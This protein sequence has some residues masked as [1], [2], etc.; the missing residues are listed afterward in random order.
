MSMENDYVDEHQAFAASRSSDYVYETGSRVAFHALDSHAETIEGDVK[1][2]FVIT[3]AAGCGKSALLANWVSLRR[4]TKHRDEF[5]FQHFVGCSPQSKQLAHLLHRLE[6]ALKEHFQLREMEIPTSEERLRW[7]LNRFLTAAGKK[8]FPARIV[9]VLDAVNCLLGE[10]STANTLHWLPSQLPQGVRIIVSTVELEQFGSNPEGLFDESRIHRTYTE[11]RRRK[12][13]T[14]HLQP[15]SV[16]VRHLII[17]SFLATNQQSLQLLK[18]AQQFRIV[19]AKASSQPLF[20]RT[21]LYA[22]LLGSEMS[23]ATIDQQV[24]IYLAAEVTPVLIARI[25][26]MCSGYVDSTCI[27]AANNLR[28]ILTALYSSRHGLSEIEMWGVAELATG[29][30]L[31]HEQ[32]ACIRRILR[33]FTFSV[34]GLRSLSHVEYAAVIYGDYIRSPEMHIRA[35][36][37]M[38][39]YFGGLL[40]CDRKLD[41]LPYHLEV[42]GNWHRLRAVLVEV[43]MFRLWWTHAHKREF[44]SLWASLTASCNLHAP[45]RK[46]V[47]GEFDDTMRCAQPPRPCLD[48][49]EEYVR[50]VDEFKFA[51]SPSDDELAAVILQIGDFLLE[52]ATLSLEE[53]ADVP[54]FIHPPIPNDDLAS[55]GVPFLSIDKDGNSVLN[56]PVVELISKK[57][58]ISGKLGVVDMSIKVNEKVPRCST[59][60]YHRWM[61]IQFPWVCLANCGERFLKGV[62][63]RSSHQDKT[64]TTPSTKLL[65]LNQFLCMTPANTAPKMSSGSTALASTMKAAVVDHKLPQ[66]SFVKSDNMLDALARPPTETKNRTSKSRHNFAQ[67]KSPQNQ[68]RGFVDHF[69]NK[70]KQLRETIGSYRNEL[71]QLRQER[72]AVHRRYD[73]ICDE[74]N[75]LSKMHLSTSSLEAELTRLV[76]RLERTERGHRMAKLLYRNY[77]CVKLMCERHPAHSQALIDELEAKLSQDDLFIKEVQHQLR[78][79]IFESH[80]F[81]ANNKILHRAAQ[82]LTGLQNDMLIQ[83]IRQRENLQRTARR[84]HLNHPT[85]GL[86]SSKDSNSGVKPGGDGKKEQRHSQYK[87]VLAKDTALVI[88]QPQELAS[89]LGLKWETQF[90]LIQKRTLLPNLRDFFCKFYLAQSLQTQMCALHDAAE[91]RQRKVKHMLSQSEVELEQVRYDSQSIVGSRSREARDMQLRLANQLMRHKHVQEMALMAESLHRTAFG[92]IKHVCTMLGIPPPDKDTPINEIIHQVESVLE[93]LMEERDRSAQKLVGHQQVTQDTVQSN[94]K[95]LRTPEL[96]AA[97][98]HFETSKSLIAHRLPAKA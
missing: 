3:G 39:R 16:E 12:C 36:H 6:S 15:L 37:L 43:K 90:K 30:S 53:A 54:K 41:A 48:L 97:L 93:S 75:E 67:K 83:R 92:G 18:Q 35:H 42:S 31:P 17:N 73:G 32:C 52:F 78:K 60:F 1:L 86:L 4:K 88:S 69:A 65:K 8:Q 63:Q 2:P 59:Y 38:A 46:L 57:G 40:P 58:N 64:A 22:L 96:D 72:I 10:S 95:C 24:E 51:H 71:D 45:V 94:E 26:E 44:L 85:D 82:D 50:S 87:G 21:V 19:T 66:I 34:N 79:N 77:E 14:I 84:K 23:N 20:L 68:Q 80:D 11:L 76:E 89:Y 47:T 13:P 27:E 28:R 25:L 91:L 81:A 61:W 55:L 62:A 5:L 70:L 56:T 29:N 98:E 74:V 9:I 7:S 33:D 49:V